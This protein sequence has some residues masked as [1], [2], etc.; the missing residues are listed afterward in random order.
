MKT[1]FSL[2]ALGLLLPLAACE[3]EE[4]ATDVDVV[5]TDPVVTAP[6][7]DPMMS[8]DMMADTTGVTAQATLD[9]AQAAGGLTSLAP[10]AA[11][12][13]IDGWISK[14]EGNPDAAPIVENLRTLRTQ[15]TATPIDGAAVGQTLTTL[16]EQTTSVAGGDAALE[17]LG[18]ALSSAGQML[19]SGNTM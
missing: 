8:D 17:Q 14:L 7:E 16:G 12:S 2:L 6:A 9:A 19:T 5:E 4:P 18:S 13:N 10:D 1:L 3:T 15:L 11:V